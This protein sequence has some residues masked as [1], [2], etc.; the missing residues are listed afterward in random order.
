MGN[1][2]PKFNVT[3]FVEELKK[4]GM[5]EVLAEVVGKCFDKFHKY[6]QV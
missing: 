6:R 4:A 3:E 1:K 5:S 2:S